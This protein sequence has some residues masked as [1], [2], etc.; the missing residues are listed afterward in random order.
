[1]FVPVI[2]PETTIDPPFDF[3]VLTVDFSRVVN[4]SVR[5]MC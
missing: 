5:R 1:M 3:G 2:L 4:V